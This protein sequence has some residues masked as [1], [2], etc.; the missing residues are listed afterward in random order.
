MPW[1]TLSQ[2]TSP[3]SFDANANFLIDTSRSTYNYELP[4]KSY[5]NY[6]FDPTK[7]S[8]STVNSV[9]FNDLQKQCARNA[10]S[11]VSSITGIQFNELP[12]GPEW[13]MDLVFAYADSTG[14]DNSNV[15]L[16]SADFSENTTTYDSL[17]RIDTY[18]LKDTIALSSQY[19]SIQNTQS[20]YEGYECLLREIGHA[21][22]LKYSQEG[23]A[24][25]PENLD[26]KDITLMS[27]SYDTT[28]YSAFS[29]LDVKALN[30]L[31]GGDGLLGKYGLTVDANGN[32]A[33]GGVSPVVS[34]G[35]GASS[36]VAASGASAVAAKQGIFLVQT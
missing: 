25:L 7:A 34:P 29:A 15:N 8:I 18:D 23:P 5:I 19:A 14:K 33:A 24:L 26:H 16:I 36:D 11:Y 10:L 31:Y 35:T 4:F 28:N 17:G 27:L 13:N 30:W 3:M 21:L 22:G 6:S 2:V 9:G 1:S 12:D 32:P 20:G